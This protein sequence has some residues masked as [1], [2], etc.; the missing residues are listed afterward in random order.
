MMND[1]DLAIAQRR[2]CLDKFG[3]ATP[4]RAFLV[5]VVIALY[6]WTNA[7]SDGWPYWTKPRNAARKAIGHIESTTYEANRQQELLDVSDADTAKA[8]VPIKS[9][10]TR[11]GYTLVG[12]EIVRKDTLE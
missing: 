12:A 5:R 1:Y 7:N 9:F 11:Q 6:H 10:L 3:P 2:F 8:L 4:N